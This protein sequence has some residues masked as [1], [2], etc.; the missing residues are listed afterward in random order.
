M[1]LSQAPTKIVLPFAAAGG[2][3]NPIPV[4]SQTGITPGAASFTDG[5][6]PLTRTPVSAGGIPPSGLDMNGIMFMIS[7]FSRWANA[8]AGF[9]YDNTFATDSNVDGYPQGARLLRSDG[10]GYWL[11]TVDNNQSDP[12]VSTSAADGWVPNA[13]SGNAAVSV[14]N[15]N[16]TL[17]PLQYGLPVIT[18]SGTL[19]ANLNV[20]F[21]PITGSW[22]IVN[23]TTGAF[24]ITC[25][26]ASGAGVGI[27]SG[28]QEIVG[29]GVNIYAISP[30]AAS[31]IVSS[32]RNGFM[33]VTSASSTATFT[34]DEVILETGLGGTAYKL[35]SY[36]GSIN[37]GTTGAG[38]MDT[39]SAPASGY[40]ATYAIYNPSTATASTL[41]V[42][43][44]STVAP[45]IYGGSHMP[46]GYT[47]SALVSVWPTNGSS[48]FVDGI[49]H[50]RNIGIVPVTVLNTS[51]QNGSLTSLSISAA[52]PKNAK[53]VVANILG[54]SDGSVNCAIAGSSTGIGSTNVSYANLADTCSQAVCPTIT[55]QTIY[56]LDTITSGTMINFQINIV[57]YSF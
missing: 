39:G 34:A 13:T 33:S 16:V 38:G 11:N 21:P 9:V 23:N 12:E 20:I 40:V 19:T 46:S 45:S 14:S 43:T 3:N 49:L 50:D 18:F 8:G 2:K 17:T 53:S 27:N 22:I 42:D 32:I 55:A 15:A 5:F 24:T 56:Y 28:V 1:E 10:K 25:K 30:V 54:S 37:L 26:T 48:Q 57:G 29:D 51:S 47:A 7:A 52:V 4:P 41:S 44:T 36:S 6:P 31:G 35:S